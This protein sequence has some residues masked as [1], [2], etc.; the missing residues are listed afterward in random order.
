[1]LPKYELLS[2]LGNTSLAG[3][4]IAA[5][6]TDPKALKKSYRVPS[7]QSQRKL[8]TRCPWVRILHVPWS[9]YPSTH[10]GG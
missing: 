6:E 9:S 1:M 5:F 8:T 10:S 4:T 3:A 7:L 2:V